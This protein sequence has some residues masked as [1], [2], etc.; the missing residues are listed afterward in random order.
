VGG[1]V[2]HVGDGQRPAQVARLGGHGQLLLLR[3]L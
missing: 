3:R 2:L 1:E